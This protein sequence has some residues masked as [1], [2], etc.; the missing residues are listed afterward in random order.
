MHYVFVQ[1]QSKEE[2]GARISPSVQELWKTEQE[3]SAPSLTASTALRAIA[4][5]SV[6]LIWKRYVLWSVNP[7]IGVLLVGF[8]PSMSCF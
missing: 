1:A 7:L 5:Y 6:R 2:V 8:W 3:V 4:A